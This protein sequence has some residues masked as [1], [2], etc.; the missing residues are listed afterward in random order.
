[1]KHV[2]FLERNA[3]QIDASAIDPNAIAWNAD[4]PFDEDR[5]RVAIMAEGYDVAASR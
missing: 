5:S 3:I 2:G 4:D 1:M